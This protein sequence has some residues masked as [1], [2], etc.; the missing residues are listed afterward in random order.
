MVRWG[1]VGC[2]GEVRIEREKRREGGN[3]FNVSGS[4]P[5]EVSRLSWLCK[6]PRERWSAEGRRGRVERGG[7]EGLRWKERRERWLPFFPPGGRLMLWG[8][9][10]LGALLSDKVGL[11]PGRRGKKRAPG[12]PRAS[13][14]D[15]SALCQVSTGAQL[16]ELLLKP[17][18][19]ITYE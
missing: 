13:S 1:G 16:D 4:E 9:V 2:T 14:L 19:I 11:G 17:L 6:L 10:I 7:Y 8:R 18:V 3:F 5:A 12:P 15:S